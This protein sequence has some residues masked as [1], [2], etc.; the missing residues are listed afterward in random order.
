MIHRSEMCYGLHFDLHPGENDVNLG[1]DVS[2][3]N[4]RQLIETVRPEYITYDCKGHR[5]YAGFP[6]QVGIPAPNLRQDSLAIWREVTQAY[7][8]PLAVHYSGVQDWAEVRKHP[9]WGVQNLEGKTDGITTSTFGEYV[10]KLLIPQLK[11][12]IDRYHINGVWLDGECWGAQ[13]DYS[14]MA[15]KAWKENTGD[16]F[17]P[18][19]RDDP[20]YEAFMNFNRKN[21]EAYV[22]HWVDEM[23]RYKPDLDCCSNWI[24]S[25]L[26][27]EPKTVNVDVLSGDFDPFLSVD[28]ART[29]CRYLQN[30]GHPWE[31]LSWGFDVI[32]DQ[33]SCIKMPAQL[34]QEA[35][36]VMMHGGGLLNYFQ[37]TRGGYINQ[38][39]IETAAEISQFCKERKESCFRSTPV[40]QV[41][42][43]YP[44]RD[45]LNVRS[46]CVYNWGSHRLNEVEGVL[47]A[48][49][50]SQYS[51]DVMAEHQLMDK[52]ERYPYVIV[53]ECSVLPQEFVEK[54]VSYVQNGGSLFLTGPKCARLFESYLGVETGE[55]R[56]V[57]TSMTT[58]TGRKIAANGEW[59][60][61]RL[62]T[63]VPLIYR[64]EGQKELA[65]PAFLDVRDEGVSEVT[66]R[67]T[68]KFP[69]ITVNRLG[70]GKIAAAFGDLATL[71]FENHHPFIRDIYRSVALE[72]FPNPALRVQSPYTLDV[73]LRHT[74]RGELSVHLMNTTNM[75][76]GD[77]RSFTD[78][79]PE[80]AGITVSVKTDARPGSITLEPEKKELAFT[81][82]NGTATFTVPSFHIHSVAVIR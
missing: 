67:Y 25:A 74:V 16:D 32:K 65:D 6:T 42:V 11:E 58:V 28:R 5:G 80:I 43:L 41:A 8:I 29:E 60:V 35:A 24:Y 81:Y 39:I 52:M 46:E 45:H 33:G 77:R 13:L 44:T 63:A 56:K 51:C 15:V 71:Y 54:A 40:P 72:L 34:K 68:T 75:P 17:P 79:I 2:E 14:P 31:L 82:E 1:A 47:H 69:A 3:E 70:K 76:D 64:Y 48:M 22:A 9:E 38:E 49:L 27:P 21:F 61:P 55:S 62:T 18:T 53:P 10:D 12:I 36:I 7:D 50:E 19:E 59:A 20:R 30:T 26:M 37:P 78:Y 66:R 23:H 73:S 4:I 57:R